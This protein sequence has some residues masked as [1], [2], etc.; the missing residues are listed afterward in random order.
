MTGLMV[1]LTEQQLKL[2]K[3][4]VDFYAKKMDWGMVRDC[5]QKTAE[6]VTD[7]RLRLSIIFKAYSGLTPPTN[8]NIDF[9]HE[10]QEKNFFVE[11]L[12]PEIRSLVQKHCVLLDTGR[13][14]DVPAHARQSEKVVARSEEKSEKKK[15]KLGSRLQ[16]AQLQAY[17]SKIQHSRGRG[18]SGKRGRAQARPSTKN[19][20]DACYRCGSYRHW[21]RDEEEEWHSRPED[22]VSV[23]NPG[24]KGKGSRGKGGW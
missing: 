14:S 13:L 23:T 5:V 17:E 20:S 3:R 2:V 4:L 19:R 18:R 10:Q 15:E 9:P 7:Y 21:I 8:P 11:G 12:R 6:S 22:G 1:Q 16:M 24:A